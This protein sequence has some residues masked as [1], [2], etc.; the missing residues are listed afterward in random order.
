LNSPHLTDAEVAEITEPLT[1]GAARRKFFERLGCKV[2]KTKPNGQPL[3]SRDDYARAIS[4]Q[5][6]EK[7]PRG[8]PKPQDEPDWAA[9]RA[10]GGKRRFS[11]VAS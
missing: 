4:A 11:V 10:A 7:R 2:V 9:L 5:P 8:G 3:V 1:Q 6:P